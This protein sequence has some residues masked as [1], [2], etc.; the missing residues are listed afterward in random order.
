MDVGSG[1]GIFVEAIS[2]FGPDCVTGLDA[3]PNCVKVAELHRDLQ[4]NTGLS[5]GQNICYVN[6]LLEDWVRTP[7][8]N[9]YDI[10]TA[11]EIIEHVD[12]PSV[13]IE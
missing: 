3:N 10:T 13:F 11:F 7:E 5:F 2:R 1:G 6:S 9:P 4:K 8:F 12:N